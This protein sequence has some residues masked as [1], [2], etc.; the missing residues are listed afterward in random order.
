MFRGESAGDGPTHPYHQDA[1][2]GTA[3][4]GLTANES[5]AIRETLPGVPAK[6]VLPTQTARL[7]LSL[8]VQIPSLWDNALAGYEGSH[9]GTFDIAMRML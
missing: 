5:L 9:T 3:C 4:Q 6:R 8:A 7:K 2:M 1:L